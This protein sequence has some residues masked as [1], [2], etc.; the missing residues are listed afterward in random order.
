VA[1]PVVYVTQAARKK[2]LRD[3]SA[4]VDIRIR[5]SFSEKTFTGHNVV[6]YIDNGAA[7]TVVI[8]ARY[9][10]PQKS[11]D[12]AGSGYGGNAAG[13]ASM[14][15]LARM[16]VS[17]K[18]KNNNYLFVGFSGSDQEAFGSKFMSGHPPADA[19]QLNYLLDLDRIMPPQDSSYGLIIGGYGSSPA[20]WGVCRE[21]GQKMS[22]PFHLDSSYARPGD[23]SFF[24]DRRIPA[25]VFY[26]GRDD[27][28][29]TLE[30]SVVKYVF[31]V[32]GAANTRG[33]LEFIPI[34][35][36]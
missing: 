4:S 7:S 30:L 17:S 25:L 10:R 31:D 28:G 13:V 22:F 2:Y 14:I 32:V 35:K 23:Q 36:I 21:V 24:Y 8:G 15:E 12:S 18:T 11:A 19:K 33:K 3:E 5:T 16:L 6:G 1:I 34:T 27:P 26:V 9:D 29:H 20:W